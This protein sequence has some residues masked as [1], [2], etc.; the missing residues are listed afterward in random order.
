MKLISELLPKT[1]WGYFCM[2]NFISFIRNCHSHVHEST[3]LLFA[4]LKV[5]PRF[6]PGLVYGPPNLMGPRVRPRLTPS[7]SGPADINYTVCQ[8][9]WIDQAVLRSE[10]MLIAT[11]SRA[12][13]FSQNREMQ[14]KT[15]VTISP[16]PTRINLTIETIL[17]LVPDF[18]Q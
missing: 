12:N 7:L 13:N 11:H 6:S 18:R 1:T 9:I 5:H 17:T 15:V 14:N 3:L 16:R 4:L 2:K 8:P 10:I